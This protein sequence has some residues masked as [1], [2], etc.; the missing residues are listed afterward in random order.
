VRRRLSA[1]LFVVVAAVLFLP[2]CL[3]TKP[4]EA[5]A[6]ETDALYGPQPVELDSAT[7]A[8]VPW[9]EVFDDPTLRDLI[10]EAL[11]N[12]LNLRDAMQQVRIAEA[13]LQAAQG[14]LFPDLFVGGNASYNEPSDNGPSGAGQGAVEAT[15]QYGVSASTS[16]EVDVWGRLTSAKRAQVA[17][18]LET[19]AVRR[20]VQTALIADV[21]RA[22]YQLLALDRQLAITEETIENRTDDLQT[23]RSLKEGGVVTNVAVERSRAALASARASRPSIQQAITERE[24]T[25]STLLGRPA[26]DIERT[27]LADQAPLD[28]LA[29]GVPAQLLRNRP[30]VVAAE[31]RYRSAFAL[32]NSARA[33]FYPSVTLTAEGGFE[34]LDAS[35]LLVPGSLFYNLVGGLTQPIFA[36]NENEARLERRKAQQTQARLN[37]RRTLLTAGSEVSSALSRYRNTSERIAARQTQLEALEAAVT[38]SRELLR[39]G[40]ETYLQVLTAQQEYLAAQLDNVDDRLDRLQ[41]GVD[42]YRALG[43]GWDRAENPIAGSDGSDPGGAQTP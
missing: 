8:D 7:L 1:P 20:G 24:N 41:A 38:Q 31:Y 37:L 15:D 14:A 43:G 33:A 12:N 39:Y 42:L 28:S 18:L 23:V 13:N 35:D 29:A 34:S 11:R 36:Q 27:R 2:G 16:W 3:A 25:L 30:D 5:P 9:P 19:E 26:G 40:E 22:Y 32:T 4:Y 6:P 17:A 10:R 21:A